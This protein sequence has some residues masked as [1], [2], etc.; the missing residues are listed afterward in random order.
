M[1]ASLQQAIGKNTSIGIELLVATRRNNMN[2]YFND[3]EDKMLPAR[4]PFSMKSL[5]VSLSRT[6]VRH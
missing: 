5:Q 2:I 1:M 4:S 6:I 3:Y